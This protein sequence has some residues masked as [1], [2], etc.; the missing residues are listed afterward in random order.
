MITHG[1]G[2]ISSIFLIKAKRN[3]QVAQLLFDNQ[4]YDESANRAYYAAFQAAL[5]ALSTLGMEVEGMS[6]DAVQASFNNE[7]IHK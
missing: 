5:T 4:F 2:M 3:I 6:H 1:L 7:F